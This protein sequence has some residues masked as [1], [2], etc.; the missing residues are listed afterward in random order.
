MYVCIYI[1]FCFIDYAEVYHCVN[2]SKLWK[3][4]IDGN[5]RPPYL[6]PEKAV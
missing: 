3:I 4:L 2:H 5:T 6:S 1:H